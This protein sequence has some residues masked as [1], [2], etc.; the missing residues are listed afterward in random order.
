[1]IL[2]ISMK[3]LGRIAWLIWLIWSLD[4]LYSFLFDSFVGLFYFVRRFVGLK[5]YLSRVAPLCFFSYATDIVLT[6]MA[7]KAES[8]G[9]L[10]HGPCDTQNC[11]NVNERSA[12]DYKVG[13][14][15]N[16]LFW[17]HRR[18]PSYK[19]HLMDLAKPFYKQTSI[20]KYLSCLDWW[21]LFVLC[22]SI[23]E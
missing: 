6:S 3:F 18:Y 4:L 11:A 12:F 10:K 1:M 14:S 16:R 13:F 8:V 7:N 15:P 22:I 21:Y 9:V 19:D 17:L 2:H 20:D 23:G 5:H